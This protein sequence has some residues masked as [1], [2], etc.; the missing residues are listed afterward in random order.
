VPIEVHADLRPS[1]EAEFSAIA[2]TVMASAFE[3]HNE[4][5]RFF[6]ERVYKYLVASRLGRSAEL[7]IPIDVHFGTFR[8]RYYLDML[9]HGTAA[10]EW[11]AAE[12]LAPEHRAQLLNYLMLCDL[13]RGKLINVGSERVEHEFVNMRRPTSERVKFS[14]DTSRFAPLDDQDEAFQQFLVDAVA[15]WGTGLHI[16]LY[17]SAIA[18]IMGGE[19]AVLRNVD[20]SINGKVLAQQLVRVTCSGAAFKVTTLHDNLHCFEQ[21]ARAF[22]NYTSLPAMHWINVNRDSLQFVTLFGSA[23]VRK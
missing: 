21:H 20:V 22:V 10:F 6:D 7:E 19:P 5:G 12:R 16:R 14:V 8:K 15:D 2:Y 23:E 4:I 17:E 9:V 11:K 3:V 1:S 18:H 13:P